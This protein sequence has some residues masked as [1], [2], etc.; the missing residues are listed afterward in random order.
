MDKDDVKYIGKQIKDTLRYISNIQY[1]LHVRP[2]IEDGYKPNFTKELLFVRIRD[3]YFFILTYLEA[4]GMSSLFEVFRNRYAL[5]ID[6]DSKLEEYVCYC[7]DDESE[8]KIIK[9]FEHFLKAFS[10]FDNHYKNEESEQLIAILKNTDHILKNCNVEVHNEAD[11]YKQVKWI[12]G[13]YYPK[14]RNRNKAAFIQQ[15]KTYNPDILIPELRT[16]IEYKYINNQSDN[17]DDFIDQ[18]K[19]DAT[20]YVG[21]SNYNY[22]IAVIYI[23]DVSVATYESVEEAWKAKKFSD[24]WELVVVNGSPTKKKK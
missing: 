11:I 8:L 24:N 19:I 14:C 18:I 20:N 2:E 5:I 7:I 16:A 21:D 17:I 15:F 23:E 3:L 22:F 1:D 10:F 12:L 6:D 13:L 9:E 4:R